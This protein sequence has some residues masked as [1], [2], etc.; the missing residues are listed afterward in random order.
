MASGPNNFYEQQRQ[1]LADRAAA[2]EQRRLDS[3]RNKGALGDFGTALKVGALK[4]PSAVTGLFDIPVAAVTGRPMV[5]EVWDA[6]GDVTGL[7]FDTWADDIAQREYSQ[8]YRQAAQEFQQ[9][10]GFG[11]SAMA[12][13]RRPLYAATMGVESVPGMVAGGVYG[14][15]L[16]GAA[17]LSGLTSV[18]VGEGAVMAGQS[19]SDL[20]GEGVD[21]RTAALASTG[22]GVL[23][24]T[25]GGLGG[26]A[27]RRLGLSDIDMLLGGLGRGT[28]DVA[29]DTLKPGVRAALTRTAGRVTGG[30]VS[31]GLFEEMPQSAIET[32]IGNVARGDEWDQDL[33]KNMAAGAVV[34][35]MMG[36]TINLMPPKRPASG[37]STDAGEGTPLL[38]NLPPEYDLNAARTRYT[39]M[40]EIAKAEAG[41]DPERAAYYANEM[42]KLRQEAEQN[43]VNINMLSQDAARKDLEANQKRAAKLQKDF[44]KQLVNDPETASTTLKSLQ[45]LQEERYKLEGFLYGAS[46]IAAPAPAA[47]VTPPAAPVDL[48]QAGSAESTQSEPFDVDEILNN[49]PPRTTEPDPR[50]IPTVRAQMSALTQ[51][52]AEEAERGNYTTASELAKQ[53]D[54]ARQRLVELGV[55][56]SQM[57]PKAAESRIKAIDT[58]VAKLQQKA[59]RQID[60]SPEAAA[61]IFAT[62]RARQNERAELVPLIPTTPAPAAA[63]GAPVDPAAAPAVDPAAPSPFTDVAALRKRVREVGAALPENAG[64]PDDRIATRLSKAATTGELLQTMEDLY[65]STSSARTTAVLDAMYQEI[66][67]YPIGENPAAQAAAEAA[68][69]PAAEVSTAPADTATPTAEVPAAPADTATPDTPAAEVP[70]V[71]AAPTMLATNAPI[72][73]ELDVPLGDVN[74]AEEVETAGLK[75]KPLVN[76]LNK[77]QTTSQAVAALVGAYDGASKINKSAIT[78]AIERLT[79][80]PVAEVLESYG[81]HRTLGKQGGKAGAPQIAMM[82]DYIVGAITNGVDILDTKGR[83]MLEEIGSRFGISRQMINKSRGRI[84]DALTAELGYDPETVRDRLRE[85][86]RANRKVEAYENVAGTV[87]VAARSDAAGNELDVAELV[88][89]NLNVIDTPSSNSGGPG[90]VPAPVL[91]QDMKLLEETNEQLSMTEVAIA[92]A[93]EL[94]AAQE[95]QLQSLGD[96]VVESLRVV[97]DQRRGPGWVM[98]SQLDTQA[99]LDF[100]LLASAAADPNNQMT[101]AEVQLEMETINEDFT[102]G[103]RTTGSVD[104]RVRELRQELARLTEVQRTTT[105]RLTRQDR[106]TA[107][108]NRSALLL[109]DPD[110]ELEALIASQKGDIESTETAEVSQTAE[111]DDD[112]D[113]D[114]PELGEAFQTAAEADDLD[115]PTNAL[116]PPLP[117]KGTAK[118]TVKKKRRIVR[119]SF[120]QGDRLDNLDPTPEEAQM[121]AEGV[122]GKSVVDALLW[123]AENTQYEDQA[124][125]AEQLA[126]RIQE[127]ESVGMV[128]EPVRVAKVGD[129]VPVQLLRSRAIASRG[130][131]GF[132]WLNGP[133]V[134][135]KVGTSFETVLHEAAHLTTMSA[136][137]FGRYRAS[138]NTEFGRLIQ[139]LTAVRNH[140]MDHINARI[141]EHKAGRLTLTEFEDRA[142]NRRNNAFADLD[143][144]IVWA[145]T[146]RSMQDYLR[147][148]P[149]PKSKWQTLWDAIVNA[150]GRFLGIDAGSENALARTLAAVE[151]LLNSDALEMADVALEVGQPLQDDVASQQAGMFSQQVDTVGDNSNANRGDF[152]RLG[153]ELFATVRP[154]ADQFTRWV[155][156]G[157]SFTSDLVQSAKELGLDSAERLEAASR[158]KATRVNELQLEVD[159]VVTRLGTLPQAIRTQTERLIYRMT[160]EGKWGFEPDWRDGAVVDPEMAA[161]FGRL[162]QEGREALV[163]AFRYS[164]RIYRAKIA[165]LQRVVAGEYDALA[166]QTTDPAEL[167]RIERERAAKLRES[168]EMIGQL[169]GPYAPLRRYGNYVVVAKSDAFRQAQANN[170]STRGMEA[171]SNHYVVEFVQ[172]QRQA[173]ARAKELEAQFGREGVWAGQ[174]EEAGTHFSET[175]FDAIRQLRARF[176]EQFEGSEKAKRVIDKL[177]VDLYISTLTEQNARH[178]A[179]KRRRVTG[180]SQDMTA[181]FATQGRADAHLLASMEYGDQIVQATTMMREESKQRREGDTHR[182]TIARTALRNELLKRQIM[183][184]DY[185]DSPVQDK[186]LA[187][188]S[189]WMLVT[190]PSYYMQN[191]F[192]PWIMSLPVLAGKFGRFKAAKELLRGTQDAGKT[193]AMS[194]WQEAANLDAFNGTAAEKR[195]LEELQNRGTLDFGI[196]AELGYWENTGPTSK[197]I[198]KVMR[199]SSMAVRKLEVINRMGTA[200]AGFRMA[201][202][203]ADPALTPEEQYAAALKYADRVT[204]ETH[205][206][207]SNAN[208]P[209]AIRYLPRIMTQFRKFQVIQVSLFARQM[210]KALA[211]ASREER[212]VARATMINL[213]GTHALFAGA[214]GIPAAGLIWPLIMWATGGDDDDPREFEVVVRRALGDN[215]MADFLLYGAPTAL[216]I[217]FSG[218][219]GA[220]QMLDPLPFADYGLDRNSY[221][222]MLAAAAGPFLSGTLPQAL[223]GINRMRQGEFAQGMAQLMPKGARDAIRAYEASNEGIKDRAGRT[224]L[225]PELL[226]FYD[227][228]MMGLGAPTLTT[229]RPRE[230]DA[231][232]RT[233][234]DHFSSRSS[235]LKRDFIEAYK[236][237]DAAKKR[238]VERDWLELQAVRVNN[239]FARQPIS[240][241]RRAPFARRREEKKVIGGVRTTEAAAGFVEPLVR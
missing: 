134:T 128:F 210:H 208:A 94:I 32:V 194:S 7:D 122:A 26:A 68:P 38:P 205:G 53:A 131:P 171:D 75:H 240:D 118:I 30:V 25:M 5:S 196:S 37:G 157:L 90:A 165:Q 15:A 232:K 58:E 186:I 85:S 79:G 200:L 9:A 152:N 217:N 95:A 123:V 66:T 106:S 207:Y 153:S 40:S 178:A 141:R 130:M 105:S 42:A 127:L 56:P 160:V 41:R 147:S 156:N 226:S 159:E 197:L 29:A 12:L 43:G 169:Q 23:G 39:S 179:Q 202:E 61:E 199:N 187:G 20:V 57:T 133:D 164:D 172:N 50:T 70:A 215:K 82:Y 170:E 51:M 221:E 154:V 144:F 175:S 116:P 158:R 132:M 55:R 150:V 117:P 28:T 8:G 98:G 234:E 166:A 77:A 101:P 238:E 21:P 107:R 151:G 213:F 173:E 216:G 222:K 111:T 35:G 230:V 88:S 229:T 227:S 69:T 142:Y 76:A 36:G 239:G 177:L 220:G 110:A 63:P 181:A 81:A 176:A 182:D 180:A 4:L 161:A 18:A 212:A 228:V 201:M 214:M 60:S 155:T 235:Q 174:K 33:G 126:M 46:P 64:R 237:N 3:E 115:V 34:G 125:I 109:A 192:Q 19:M 120:N 168:G 52:A 145:L 31:E 233:Y 225:D 203:N 89:G 99:L 103:R 48:T 84:A 223:D 163:E 204:V 93:E 195:M 96:T 73:A 80:R 193:L 219:I 162:P 136:V 183:D 206:D 47:E 27:S 59:S 11:D 167:R 114:G 62:I 100:Y 74:I 71:G 14:K 72:R 10:E 13:L 143:E 188:N 135:G 119:E 218:R 146:N 191:A 17:G 189:F 45:S 140:V 22:I 6:I 102:D 236:D 54:I 67:G 231:L 241:L 224:L 1:A 113:M 83:L 148:I 124:I 92:R 138:Q 185:R 65:E 129:Q 198:N 87:P 121:V 49:L 209:T 78:T 137:R 104:T 190:S 97:W 112:L 2:R 24:G 86:G 139:E 44:E 184:L 108:A 211:G 16:R 91:T 149:M